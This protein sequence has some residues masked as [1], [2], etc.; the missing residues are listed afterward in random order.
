MI[1]NVGALIIF[2]FFADIITLVL[3]NHHKVRD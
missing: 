1:M 3:Q 2:I